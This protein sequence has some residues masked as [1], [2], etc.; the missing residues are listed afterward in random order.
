MFLKYIVAR[1][2]LSYKFHVVK[3]LADNTLLGIA[4]KK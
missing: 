4:N 3:L 1:N 2:R